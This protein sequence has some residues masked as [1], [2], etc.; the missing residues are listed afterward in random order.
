MV[1]TNESNS[2]FAGVGMTLCPMYLSEISPLG[3]RG[4][5]G[6]LSQVVV[7]LGITTSEVLGLDAVLGGADS[8]NYLLGKLSLM[9]RYMIQMEKSKYWWFPRTRTSTI[10]KNEL[11]M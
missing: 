7:V 9:I 2:Y 11:H 1:G 3:L 6:T 4:F 5:I 10:N 8:W